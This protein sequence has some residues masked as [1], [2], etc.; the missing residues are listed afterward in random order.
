MTQ[1]FVYRW[2]HIPTGKWYIGY[3]KGTPNDGYIC[4]SKIVKPL[5]K[6]NPTEWSR[7]ILKTGTQ[8]EMLEHEVFLLKLFDAKK[9]PMSFNQTNGSKEFVNKPKKI[10]PPETYSPKVLEIVNKLKQAQLEGDPHKIFEIHKFILGK[11]LAK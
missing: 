9:D 7:K 11:V 2:T 8:Q 4:S 10:K 3:H 6:A 5:I 1:A